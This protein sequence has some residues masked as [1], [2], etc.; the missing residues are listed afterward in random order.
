M[1]NSD[2]NKEKVINVLKNILDEDQ[3]VNINN[4]SN[5]ILIDVIPSNPTHKAKTDL[6]N[7]IIDFLKSEYNPDLNTKLN[8]SLFQK[9]LNQNQLNI[10]Q[11]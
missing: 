11:M 9:V 5:E 3:I 1:V 6:S 7:K 8:L 2:F 4:F 10:F